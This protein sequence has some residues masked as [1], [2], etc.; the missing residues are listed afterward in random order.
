MQGKTTCLPKDIILLIAEQVTGL[1][2]KSMYDLHAKIC[3]I[4]YHGAKGLLF[5]RGHEERLA[6]LNARYQDDGRYRL[7]FQPRQSSLSQSL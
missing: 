6:D 4:T 2:R 7:G 3:E 1:R 5:A